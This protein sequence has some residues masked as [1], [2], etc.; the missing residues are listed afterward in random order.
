MNSR[1]ISFLT[2]GLTGLFA[3]SAAFAQQAPVG[4]EPVQPPAAEI[5]A[6]A[7]ADRVVYSTQLPSVQQLTDMARAQGT[8]VIN[9]NQTANDVTVTYRL[10]DNSTRVV[11][12][13]LLPDQNFNAPAAVQQQEQ[14]VSQPPPPPPAQVQ[15][16]EVAPPPPTVVYRY[17]DRY[18]PFYSDP[19]W[20]P[21]VPI[22]VNLG[23]GWGGYRG[24]Y[25]GGHY[26]GRHHR[27]GGH[28]RW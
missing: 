15:I 16:V 2:L 20:R 6:P 26:Y 22:S 12:Y 17:Y 19:F 3:G 27:H 9:V 18:D 11:S 4:T 7:R 14:Y 8:T 13:Q 5:S 10:N 24:G 25:Y 21:R 23:F 28:R 1:S